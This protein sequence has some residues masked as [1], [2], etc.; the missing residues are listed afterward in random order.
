MSTLSPISNFEYT[1][2]SFTKTNPGL[3][4][5]SIES[6]KYAFSAK[7]LLSSYHSIDIAD[8]EKSFE[9]VDPSTSDHFQKGFFDSIINSN[10]HKNSSGLLPPAI[11]YYSPRVVV[12]ERPPCYQMIQVAPTA[13]SQVSDTTETHYFRIPVPWQVYIALYSDDYLCSSV[14]MFFRNSP[15]VNSKDKLYLPPLTNFYTNGGICRPMYSDMAD[16]DR[17]SK[18]LSG[19]IASAYDWVWNSGAN[20]DLTESC[21]QPA[22]QS[23]SKTFLSD[24]TREIYATIPTSYAANWSY[25]HSVFSDWE[26]VPFEN[27]LDYQ[28]PVPSLS[29]CGDEDFEYYYE[30]DISYDHSCSYGNCD[31]DSSCFNTWENHKDYSMIIKYNYVDQTSYQARSSSMV[32]RFVTS[33]DQILVA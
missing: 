12:F 28:W 16:V 1:H 31:E 30:N 26:K 25:L 14:F 21:L 15:L 33:L 20:M 24:R 19:V 8:Y 23:L 6:Y 5:D 9:I 11:K 22:R 17:Y 2:L 32:K 7:P 3:P 27:I 29:N 4:S 10:V 13:A 18:D